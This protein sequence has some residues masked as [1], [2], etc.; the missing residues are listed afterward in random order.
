MACWRKPLCQP[1]DAEALERL[2]LPVAAITLVFVD[3]KYDASLSDDARGSGFDI[4]V[5]DQRDSLP[6][7]V[8]P[9]V[10]LHLTESLA[11]SVTHI[12]VQRNQQPAKPLLLMHLSSGRNG[13]EIATAHYRHH[14]VLESGAQATV[15]EHYVSLD[16][17]RHFTGSRLT[18]EGGANSQ[19]QHYK[20]A[21]ENPLCYHFAHNDLLF[22]GAE[23]QL[24]AGR[25]GTA[26]SHQYAA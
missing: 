13:D 4:T 23:Q 1:L 15:Y 6:P 24:F 26:A 21:F 18:V 22:D 2:A 20:L 25:R 11:H 8:Q 7:A 12:R 5:N 3:G 19:L 14:L 17:H 16:A 9:E 10:F